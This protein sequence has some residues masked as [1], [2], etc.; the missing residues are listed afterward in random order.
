MVGWTRRKLGAFQGEKFVDKISYVGRIMIFTKLLSYS[1]LIG[2][3]SNL[4][5]KILFIKLKHELTMWFI[6]MNDL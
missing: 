4:L 2:I 3:K 5:V 1:I 6:S